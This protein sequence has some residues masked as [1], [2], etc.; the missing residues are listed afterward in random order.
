MIGA[1]ER[2]AGLIHPTKTGIEIPYEEKGLI[3]AP[4]GYGKHGFPE[5]TLCRARPFVRSG[6]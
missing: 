1:D 5:A 6:R 2:G 4:P 3:D